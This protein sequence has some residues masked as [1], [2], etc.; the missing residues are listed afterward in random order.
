[1]MLRI[2]FISI[3]IVSISCGTTDSSFFG[4]PKRPKLEGINTWPDSLVIETFYY[5]GMLPESNKLIIRK[6]SCVLI[7]R[8][9]QTENRHAFIPDKNELNALLKKLNEYNVDKIREVPS[10]GI[11]YDAPTSGLS[12]K[13]GNKFISL[14]NGATEEIKEKNEGDFRNCYNLLNAYAAKTLESRKKNVCIKIDNSIKKSIGSLSI[15]PEVRGIDSYYDSITKLKDE[16]CFKFLEG[17]Y[18]FQIH[19]TAQ[20]KNYSTKYLASI[21][22]KIEIKGDR[23]YTLSLKNDSTLVL[24]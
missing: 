24:E 3:F 2:A 8:Q 14:S 18:S 7:E 21:Y 9:Y 12:I 20:D 13:L 16:A 23:I 19:I 10:K 5:G 17:K 4:D 22:P 15:I 6:D 1:M 11:T